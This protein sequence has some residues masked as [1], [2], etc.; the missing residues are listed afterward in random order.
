MGALSAEDAYGE[1]GG[2]PNSAEK[3][4]NAKEQ[5]GG[6]GG[7]ALDGRFERR[8]VE[9]GFNEDKHGGKSQPNDKNGGHDGGYDRFNRAE[10]P[11]ASQAR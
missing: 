5:L 4:D 11:R 6:D 8:Y 9:R 1:M 7:G 3:Q 10:T 2:Q